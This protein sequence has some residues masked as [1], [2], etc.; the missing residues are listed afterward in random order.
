[1]RLNSRRISSN[2]GWL[3]PVQTA[4]R[5]R[6]FKGPSCKRDLT[7]GAVMRQHAVPQAGKFHVIGL[8]EAA[9]TS[10]LPLGHRP[11]VSIRR[12]AD[13]PEYFGSPLCFSAGSQTHIPGARYPTDRS[14]F[15]PVRREGSLR[16]YGGRDGYCTEHRSSAPPPRLHPHGC[17]GC[18][19]CRT[20]FFR[21]S[22]SGNR[23]DPSIPCLTRRVMDG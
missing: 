16:Q 23:T 21:I 17:T 8:A 11:S 19:D 18:K 14:G 2:C 9:V 13:R 5:F 4:V 20:Q 3:S 7:Q 22:L 10:H 1:M 15:S 12:S 6:R